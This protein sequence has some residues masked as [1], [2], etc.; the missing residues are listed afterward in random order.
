MLYPNI[1][2]QDL[3]KV[4]DAVHL[5]TPIVP[6]PHTL[7]TQVPGN[8]KWFSVV[9][10][11]NAFYSIPVDPTSQFWFAFQFKGKPYTWTRMPQGYCESPAVFSAALHDNLARLVLPGESTLIQYVDDL[12]VCSP[13]SG[14]CEQDFGPHH[15]TGQQV[16]WRGQDKGNP[17]HAKVHH[18]K[19]MMGFLGTTG[20]C[21]QWILDYSNLAQPLQDIT[22]GHGLTLTDPD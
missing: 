8:C 15:H 20:Y 22:H 21:R 16:P 1:P 7:V 11:A 5:R 18:K 3:K 14:V 12:L 6:D 2:S 10:L 9:D 13:D 17:K 4:N 19:Q